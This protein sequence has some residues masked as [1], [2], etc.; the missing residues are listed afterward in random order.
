[1]RLQLVEVA[2]EASMTPDIN[3]VVSV[4]L[5][6]FLGIPLFF[7]LAHAVSKK[8]WD[9]GEIVPEHAQRETPIIQSNEWVIYNVCVS[10]RHDYG[11][12]PRDEQIVIR[13][14]AIDFLEIWCREL[15]IEY[16]LDK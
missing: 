1:M 7:F 9:L 15:D 14:M 2:N 4:F 6:F 5:F 8:V 16:P 13:K 11:L 3:I 10:Y 12:L